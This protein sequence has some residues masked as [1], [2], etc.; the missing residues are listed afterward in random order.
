MPTRSRTPSPSM[1]SVERTKE[2]LDDIR[3]FSEKDFLKYK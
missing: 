3:D 1:I 2:V